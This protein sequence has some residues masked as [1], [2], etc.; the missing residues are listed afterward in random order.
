MSAIATLEKPTS[1]HVLE[2][3]APLPKE[4]A[5]PQ[6]GDVLVIREWIDHLRVYPAR[7]VVGSWRETSPNIRLGDWLVNWEA[8]KTLTVGPRPL[9]V[10]IRKNRS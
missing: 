1:L 10:I 8:L 5:K 7:Y 9:V 4:V 3:P 2:F 6:Q